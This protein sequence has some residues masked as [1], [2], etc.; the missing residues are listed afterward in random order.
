MDL[1]FQ[2]LVNG[3][4]NGSHYA[5]LA[6]GFGLIFAT[7]KI[8]HFAY[9]PIYAVSAYAGWFVASRLALPLIAAAAFAML[10]GAAIGVLSYWLIYRPFEQ[11]GSPG[12]VSLIASLGLFIVI[13]NLI[14]LIF[15]TGSRV[16]E[17][18]S[19]GI[20]FLGPAFF[21]AIHV[22]QV[23]SL[24]VIAAALLLFLRRTSYGKAVLAMTDNAE[25][26]EIIGIRTARVS[27]M[28][29]AIGSAVAAIPAFLIL[30][31]DGAT[32]HMGFFAVFIA[33]VSVVVGGIGSIPGAVIGG[34]AVGMIE[35]LGLWQI[36]TEW[37]N[38]IAFFVLFA[39]LL[40]RPQGLFGPR[41]R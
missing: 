23:I 26:A 5:L 6:V 20:Y 31:K 28:V 13:E 3:L 37:Q 2:L 15:G 19:Y 1:F 27:V 33:F 24:A 17:N 16:I 29:F 40:F 35:S 39:V 18:V 41:R 36:P 25:M 14:G 32:P 22:A 21:T 10:V 7:T 8:V 30:L 34:L 4:V 12:L 11:R 9:G 38:S